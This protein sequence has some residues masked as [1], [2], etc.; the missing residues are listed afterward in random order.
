MMNV[1]HRVMSIKILSVRD[2]CLCLFLIPKRKGKISVPPPAVS[3]VECVTSELS[4]TESQLLGGCA[5]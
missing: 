4:F 1:S 5:H 2:Q 3:S